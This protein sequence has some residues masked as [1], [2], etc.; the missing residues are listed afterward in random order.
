MECD[1]VDVGIGYVQCGPYH[2][3][4]CGA[5]EQGPERW[6]L[7]DKPEELA[8]FEATLD[9]DEKRT[10]FYKGKVSPYANTVDGTLVDY[11]TA[12]RLYK[13]GLLDEKPR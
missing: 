7:Y 1:T 3:W 11:K 12:L 8:A 5:S 10:G 4:E 9:E 6:N 2:C 13:W